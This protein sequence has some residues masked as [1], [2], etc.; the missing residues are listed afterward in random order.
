M[1]ESPAPEFYRTER[2]TA[3]PVRDS[4]RVEEFV[5]AADRMLRSG[6]SADF[7][8]SPL[9][10][11]QDARQGVL[12]IDPDAGIAARIIYRLAYENA[13]LLSRLARAG[14]P[15]AIEDPTDRVR[16]ST[17]GRN[18]KPDPIAEMA[19]R[20]AAQVMQLSSIHTEHPDDQ[21]AAKVNASIEM[22]AE[23]ADALVMAVIDDAE[24]HGLDASGPWLN[25]PLIETRAFEVPST[26][27]EAHEADVQRDQD[28]NS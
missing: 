6:P 2:F 18:S 27:P 20:F 15:T 28:L 9:D 1:A 22:I 8:Q 23:E 7:I 25:I 11:P 13:Q 14:L 21:D 10:R 4:V 17:H 3:P 16:V 12:D 5:M 24:T 19:A 26:D